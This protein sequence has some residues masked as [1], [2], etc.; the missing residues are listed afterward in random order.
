MRHLIYCRDTSMDKQLTELF[1]ENV[2]RLHGLPRSIFLDRGTQFMAKFW[3]VLCKCLDTQDQ[4]STPYHPRTD[5]QTE[6][7]NAVMEQYLRYFVNHL[8]DDW[9]SWLTLSEF[10]ANNQ[11]SESTGVSTFLV[12][13][14]YNPKWQFDLRQA[15]QAPPMPAQTDAHKTVR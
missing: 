4:L 3:R 1:W 11:T 6:R 2:F 15:E 7:F 8:Q 12:N 10:V 14:S 5:G 13:Y 9:N